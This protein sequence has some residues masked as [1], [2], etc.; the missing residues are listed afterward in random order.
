MNQWK[1]IQATLWARDLRLRE[2][3]TLGTNW[4]QRTNKDSRLLYWLTSHIPLDTGLW[5]EKEGREGKRQH[6]NFLQSRK[7]MIILLG[8]VS[9]K[10]DQKLNKLKIQSNEHFLHRDSSVSLHERCTLHGCTRAARLLFFKIFDDFL[11]DN[12]EMC[13][14]DLTEVSGYLSV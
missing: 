5:I 14:N 4:Y 10:K 6:F 2:V 1:C 3:W 8:V 7:E 13:K 11:F 9:P 12:G